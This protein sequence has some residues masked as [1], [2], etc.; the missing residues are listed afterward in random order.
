MADQVN[1]KDAAK[2]VW[3]N[4]LW[5]LV[6]LGFIGL[7]ALAGIGILSGF[8]GD[9]CGAGQQAVGTTADQTINAVVQS[10]NRPGSDSGLFVLSLAVT[11]ALGCIVLLILRRIQGGTSWGS[12]A[13][14]EELPR[15]RSGWAVLLLPVMLILCA[16]IT[17][18]AQS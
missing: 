16:A 11:L 15:S 5:P 7:V 3:L 14:R 6:F 18:A 17:C 9:Q 13:S 10:L 8:S 4:V 2:T 12:S 1:R